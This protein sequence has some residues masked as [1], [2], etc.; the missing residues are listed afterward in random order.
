MSAR[1][2]FDFQE[3]YA[4]NGDQLNA[5]RR[6]RYKSDPDYRARVLDANRK[7]R[8]ERRTVRLAEKAEE[9]AAVK[10]KVAPRPYKIFT[11]VVK[12]V[13]IKLF[14]IGGLAAVLGCSVQAIRLW[15]KRGILPE[16]AFFSKKGDR[17]YTAEQIETLRKVAEAQGRVDDEPKEKE[18]PQGI[19]RRVRWKDKS[20]T[21]ETLFR[22]GVLARAINRTVV[23]VDQMEDL[24]RLPPTPFRAAQTKYRLYTM[25]MILAVQKIMTKFH[26]EVRGDDEWKKFHDAVK[27]EWTKSGIMGA[28]LL[29]D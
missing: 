15:E 9:Q 2:G 21:E 18:A 14:T 19:T 27:D 25:P 11:M 16:P 28:R 22:V 3:W 29:S 12:G 23:T 8:E 4:E 1:E 24:K 13:S 6:N 5:K 10:T 26:G 7:A 17:L 20:V